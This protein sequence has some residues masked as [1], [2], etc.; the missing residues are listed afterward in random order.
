MPTPPLK[1]ANITWNQDTPVS[2]D[3]D[4]MYFNVEAGLAETDHVFIKGNNLAERFSNFDGDCFTI[5]ETGFGTGLN[6]LAARALWLQKSSPETHLHFIS[7]EKHPLKPEDLAQALTHWPM[8]GDGAS[9]LLEQYPC[10]V[11]GYHTLTFDQGRVRLTLMLGDAIDAY[12]SLYGQVDAWFLDGFAPS[13]NPEM[14]QPA[15]FRQ[16]ARLS[17]SGTT[18]ATFTAA[19]FVRRGLEAEGFHV[20]KA[21]GF[22]RKREMVQASYQGP[23][24]GPS[25]TPWFDPPS[26]LKTSHAVVI[27]AGIAGCTTA[28]A[29]AQRGIRVTLL[30]RSAEV[31]SAG[32][33]NRQGALYAKLPV[34][35]NAQGQL[36]LLGLMY[37][38]RLLGQVDPQM[39]HWSHCGL[40]QLALDEKEHKRQH[41]LMEQTTFSSEIMRLVSSEEASAI[42]GTTLSAGGIYMPMG[43]WVS[44]ADLCRA[45]IQHPLIKLE[46]NCGV[47]ACTQHPADGHWQLRT[48]DNRELDTS[49]VIV[50]TAAEAVNLPQLSHLPVKPIR[51]QT[52]V[53]A[54]HA[55]DIR[56]VVCGDGYISP[57]RDGAFCFGATFDL[58]DLELSLRPEDHTYN[59]SKLRH[60]A[61]LLAQEI[62]QGSFSGHVAHRCSTA[63]Y[64]PIVGAAPCF[65]GFLHDYAKLRSDRKWRFPATPAKHWRGLYVNI[66]HGSKG[67]V[68]APLC[69]E[70]LTCAITGESLP[71][72]KNVTDAVN[73]ARF[74]IKNLIRKTI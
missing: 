54:K 58:H 24:Q 3:F 65:D 28:Y 66:G 19:G 60:V 50:C 55:A 52:T 48:S 18:L 49:T 4:D 46:L 57:A 15:L 47:V 6:F 27:G 37:T 70:M 68:T 5:A 42:A 74:I 17:H 13:K 44:P 11:P 72:E 29:L 59:L 12:S 45:L 25:A 73:P 21:P 67:L 31:A 71:L 56:T 32:S 69:A 64:L 2:V 14:W 41:Q 51:G 20:T 63:D 35:H 33:G 53:A 40:L 36:H 62:E 61:P 16:L 1:S 39:Q 23:Q 30:E 38:L 43:G 22:G 26:P 7:V 10:A 8:L 34:S 9:Q